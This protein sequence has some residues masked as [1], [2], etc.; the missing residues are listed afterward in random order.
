MGTPGGV[1][2]LPAPLGIFAML[3]P[4]RACLEPP[5]MSLEDEG[6]ASVVADR[7]SVV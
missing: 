4:L 7:K 3:V 1:N 6:V 5:M 2:A